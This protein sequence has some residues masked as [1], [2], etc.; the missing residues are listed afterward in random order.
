MSAP[1][2]TSLFHDLSDQHGVSIYD[3]SVA[4]PFLLVLLRHLGCSFC[5]KTLHEIQ[6]SVDTIRECGYNLGLVHMNA[7][8]QTIPQ[9]QKFELEHLPRFYDPKRLLYQDLGVNQVEIKHL[10]RTRTLRE[11][12]KAAIQYQGA[13]PTANPLQLPGAFLIDNGNVVAGE[14]VMYAEEQPDILSLLIYSE[15]LNVPTA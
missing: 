10:F 4:T 15:A 14:T 8:E 11:G 7:S 5:R 13:I 3:H 2:P 9:L 1:E 12:A 6:E